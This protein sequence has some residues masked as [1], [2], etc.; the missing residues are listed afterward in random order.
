MMTMMSGR[1]RMGMMTR[2][3]CAAPLRLHSSLFRPSPS[4]A[5]TLS[6]LTL[7]ADP[8]RPGLRSRCTATH[9][10]TPHPFP[11]IT[12]SALTPF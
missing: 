6:P 4:R 11:R 9:P 7:C 8:L 12:L 10:L 1:R 5:L 3:I 2:M